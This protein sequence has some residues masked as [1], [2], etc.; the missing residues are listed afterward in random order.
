MKHKI[1]RVMLGVALTAAATIALFTTIREPNLG[2]LARSQTAGAE[3]QPARIVPL[4]G[5]PEG[6]T[7]VVRQALR[8]RTGDTACDRRWIL[9]AIDGEAA[10]PALHPDCS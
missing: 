10:F 1:M 3:V 5:P 2:R 8:V 9:Y 4:A 6:G 7:T